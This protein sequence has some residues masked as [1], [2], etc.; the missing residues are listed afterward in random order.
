MRQPVSRIQSKLDLRDIPPAVAYWP[1]NRGLLSGVWLHTE[2]DVVSQKWDNVS[3]GDSPPQ[4]DD[5]NQ[6]ERT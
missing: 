2:E 6:T 5:C 3:F 1:G 4:E